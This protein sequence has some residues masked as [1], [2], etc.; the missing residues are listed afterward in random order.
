MT[1]V[2]ETS[3]KSTKRKRAAIAVVLAAAAILL[4]M[5]VYY[6]LAVKTYTA[7]HFGITTVRS[8]VDRNENGIDDYGDFL[9]GA[10]ADAV[11]HPTYDGRYWENG[12]PPDDIGVC[13]DVVWRAFRNAGYSLM[14]MVDADIASDPKAYP[15]VTER[16]DKIDFRRVRNLRVFFDRHAVPL[17]TDIEKTEEWQPGDIVIFGENKHIGIVSDKRDA[18]GHAYIIH[19]GGQRDREENFLVKGSMTVAAHYRFDASVIDNGVLF[20]WDAA[21]DALLNGQT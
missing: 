14:K 20:D 7:E 11:N 13:A 10:R 5:L 2:P 16:D 4:T 6:A 12:Y 15:G 9:L 8:L 18:F 1:E 21:D 19:N 3:A 17:T